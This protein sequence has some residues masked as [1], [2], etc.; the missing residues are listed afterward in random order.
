MSIVALLSDFGTT[1][2]FTASVKAVILDKNP[3]AIL[4]DISHSISS[5]DIKKAAFVLLSCFSYFP[6][7]TVFMA[8]VDPGVGSK[9]PG[10]AV[11]TKNFFFIGPDNGIVSL[12]AKADGIEKIIELKNKKYFLKEIS[13]TFH[14]RD[15][16]APVAAYLSKGLSIDK[17]GPALG[18]IEK[19]DFK[20]AQA[21]KNKIEG[22]IVCADKFGNLIT[23]ITYRQ[24]AYFLKVNKTFSGRLNKKNINKIYCFYDQ[25][26]N[27]EPFFIQGSSDFIEVA[28]KNKSAEDFFKLKKANSKIIVEN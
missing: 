10:I 19:A 27:N 28:L 26:K 12:A 6:K 8:V 20:L 4:I 25:A 22:E 5:Y 7:K 13:P 1:D 3:K 2:G 23:N 11:K 9:R 18:K 16:F 15:I 21:T 14:G 24:L 17:L